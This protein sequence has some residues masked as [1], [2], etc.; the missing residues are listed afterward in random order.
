M[1]Q[2]WSS[3]PNNFK[4]GVIYVECTGTKNVT[5]RKIKT[6]QTKN[7]TKTLIRQ[8]EIS[9]ATMTGQCMVL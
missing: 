3:H 8:Q 4:K 5:A 7:H 2:H 6:T 9:R 1:K